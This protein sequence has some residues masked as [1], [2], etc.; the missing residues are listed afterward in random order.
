MEGISRAR[1]RLYSALLLGFCLS[2]YAEENA[3]PVVSPPP[4]ALICTACH[5]VQA[6]AAHKIG[7]N[8]WGVV[9]RAVAGAPG[10]DYS[11][12]LKMLGGHWSQQRL[13]SYLQSPAAMAPDNRMA[14]PGI[15]DAAARAVVIAYLSAL[16]DQPASS[17]APVIAA[18]TEPAPGGFDYDGLPPGDGRETVYARCSACHSLMIVKQQGLSR[19][20]WQK[21]LKWM[22]E[23]Q[24][25]EPFTKAE[26]EQV[27]D[28]LSTHYGG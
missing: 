26:L 11:P 27:L 4:Q 3:A 23:E 19:P 8:L 10:Y 5:S 16:S 12:A 21:T 14:F 28:Y 22:V 20:R 9:G 7:P 2:A 6:G 17:T 15:A 18:E 1:W 25:M 13:D 24:G